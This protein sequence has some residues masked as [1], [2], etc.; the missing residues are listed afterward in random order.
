MS[1]AVGSKAKLRG[2]GDGCGPFASRRHVRFQDGPAPDER[3]VRVG[4]FLLLRF[5]DRILSQAFHERFGGFQIRSL[6]PFRELAV[7]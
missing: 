2:V 6:E 1:V 5:G 4:A 3:C 7:D